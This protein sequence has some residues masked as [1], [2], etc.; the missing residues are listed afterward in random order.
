[1]IKKPL[2][3]INK[4]LLKFLKCEE[5]LSYKY[6]KTALI[7]VLISGTNV[8]KDPLLHCCRGQELVAECL[9]HTAYRNPSASTLLDY[10]PLFLFQSLLTVVSDKE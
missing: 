5:Y 6:P 9:Q 3:I 4:R 2:T 8:H 10:R 1:M 7:P